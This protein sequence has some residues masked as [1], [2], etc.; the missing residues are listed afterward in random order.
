MPTLK[1]SPTKKVPR[2]TREGGRVDVDEY[3]ASNPSF[4]EK[5]RIKVTRR[6]A[7]VYKTRQGVTV[8]DL[9][10]HQF[11]QVV[12]GVKDPQEAFKESGV[13]DWEIPTGEFLVGNVK[14]RTRVPMKI[15]RKM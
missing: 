13:Q 5:Q 15:P 11:N 3:M 12:S 8:I 4:F 2:H 7:R 6:D 1:R 14:N 9:P 10:S